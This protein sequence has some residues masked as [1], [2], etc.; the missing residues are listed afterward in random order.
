MALL[1]DCNLEDNQESPLWNGE[2]STFLSCPS[3]QARRDE[4][5][6]ISSF[7]CPE[8]WM[9]TENSAFS[10]SI[11]FDCFLNSAC[12]ILLDHYAGIYWA[13][14]SAT[15]RIMSPFFNASQPKHKF[16]LESTT[17]T[18]RIFEISWLDNVISSVTSQ[19]SGIWNSRNTR[20]WG[21]RRFCQIWF[22]LATVSAC[23]VWWF[24]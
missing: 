17:T 22:V 2:G 8:M 13:R 10:I 24:Q 19:L 18:G 15:L 5:L 14:K 11:F 20:F 1:T 9:Q 23:E 6:V 3:V 7:P 12:W 21:L 4:S 16:K